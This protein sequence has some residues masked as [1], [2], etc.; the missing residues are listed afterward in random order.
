MDSPQDS[1][2]YIDVADFLS[3]SRSDAVLQQEYNP[4]ITIEDSDDDMATSSPMAEPGQ[5]VIAAADS[6]AADVTQH[7]GVGEGLALGSLFLVGGAVS[8]LAQ[9]LPVQPVVE[10]GDDNQAQVDTSVDMS[11]FACAPEVLGDTDMANEADDFGKLDAAI[12]AVASMLGS[13]E[14]TSKPIMRSHAEDGGQQAATAPTTAWDEQTSQTIAD[15]V[16]LDVVLDEQPPQ[17]I[18]DNAMPAIAL[19]EQTS[20]TIPVDASDDSR[21]RHATVPMSTSGEQSAQAIAQDV[22][23]ACLATIEFAQRLPVHPVIQDGDD[24]QAQ[25]EARA[26]MSILVCHAEVLG[27]PDMTHEADAAVQM[28]PILSPDEQMSQANME[29]KADDKSQMDTCS[30]VLNTQSIRSV[31][32]VAE[33]PAESATSVLALVQSTKTQVPATEASS[34]AAGTV[35]YLISKRAEEERQRLLPILEGVGESQVLRGRTMFDEEEGQAVLPIVS[36]QALQSNS[37]ESQGCRRGWFSFLP[38]S[39]RA[40][41]DTKRKLEKDESKDLVAP[42]AKRYRQ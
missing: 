38:C 19:D 12:A 9:V 24:D 4:S 16:V 6:S 17:P 37:N 34:S 25:V 15:D 31:T 33:P 30:G 21:Q 27:K 11:I 18:V 26:D 22:L 3:P 36:E 35:Q 23:T 2:N 13:V 28:D 14:Q 40:R 41:Q 8:T 42:G 29:K 39:R 32:E 5:E 20:R 7:A 10:D 1:T